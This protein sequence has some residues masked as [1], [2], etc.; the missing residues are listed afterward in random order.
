M[1]KIS[2]VILMLDYLNTGNKYS[3]KELA[4][5]L[6]VTERMVRYYKDELQDA[7]IF[8]ESFMGPNGGYFLTKTGS[9]YQQFTK[10]DIQLLNV[11]FDDLQKNQFPLL[12]RYQTMLDKVNHIYAIEEERSKYLDEVEGEYKDDWYQLFEQYIKTKARI[13]IVYQDVNGDLKERFI[14][15]LHLFQYENT[16]YVAAFCELRN[17]IR[18]F[19]L[20]RIKKIK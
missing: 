3:I 13:C 5:R 1:S 8:I 16:I 18:H 6:E 10:Y 2:N 7:G 19:E 15:P 12:D 11:V 9:S 14:H 17:D 4:K 20:T